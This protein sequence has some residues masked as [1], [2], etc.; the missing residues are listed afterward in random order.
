M[1]RRFKCSHSSRCQPQTTRTRSHYRS[2]NQH[3]HTHQEQHKHGINN[4]TSTSTRCTVV[5]TSQP[6]VA[7]ALVGIE[8]LLGLVPF[9]LHNEL[10]P[11][12]GVEVAAVAETVC[13]GPQHHARSR[14]RCCSG[15]DSCT[16]LPRRGEHIAVAHV[17]VCWDSKYEVVASTIHFCDF[18]CGICNLLMI[19][20]ILLY[21]NNYFLVF[22][23][24]I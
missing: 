12:R 1:L 22:S 24:K 21:H 11:T 2:H 15:G 19:V 23:L 7:S 10:S 13:A 17:N 6:P 4:S 20:S 18:V 8:H 5:P 14:K 3:K 9:L 16:I